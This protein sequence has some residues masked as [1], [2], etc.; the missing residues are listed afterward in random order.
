MY[1]LDRTSIHSCP[2]SQPYVCLCLLHLCTYLLGCAC[3][4]TLT[5]THKDINTEEDPNAPPPLTTS[6]LL[7]VV[8]PASTFHAGV[9]TLTHPSTP[10][11]HHVMG[12]YLLGLGA[13]S[14]FND[15]Y[16]VKWEP[17]VRKCGHHQCARGV[18]RHVHS[19]SHFSLTRT[20]TYA[21]TQAR[22]STH[23]GTQAGRHASRQAGR[24]AGR[25]ARTC[26]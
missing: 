16:V 8:P 18:Y 11:D 1:R 4:N 3:N 24:Q 23:A 2:L 5:D 20:R 7:L 22:A 12:S 10:R 17:A 14:R 9:T 26:I 6:T 13:R 15:F 21:R 19:H 25:H